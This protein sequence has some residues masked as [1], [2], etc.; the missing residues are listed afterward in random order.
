MRVAPWANRHTRSI[1]FLL[2]ALVAG[3]LLGALRL[4]VALFPRTNFPRIRV[5]LSAGERPA[6]QMTIQ[7][8]K[9]VEETVRAIPGV[10]SLRSTTSRG[11]AEVWITFDWGEDMASALLQAESQVN[12]IIPSLPQGTSFE[13]RRMDPTVFSTISYSLISDA[14]S[15]S[16][17]PDIPS[18]VAFF[19]DGRLK[20]SVG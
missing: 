12:K 5:N 11:N 13:V 8:T 4:P 1:L 19:A 9:P 15:L 2:V 16:E 6:E 14:R 20:A 7:V 3:G 10:R 18:L 17:L